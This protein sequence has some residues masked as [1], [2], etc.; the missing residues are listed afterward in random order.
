MHV[1]MG[2]VVEEDDGVAGDREGSTCVYDCGSSPDK[3]ER[4]VDFS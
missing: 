3:R 4:G 1:F 2:C